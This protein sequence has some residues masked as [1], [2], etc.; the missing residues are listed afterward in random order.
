[1]EEDTNADCSYSKNLV[2]KTY[3]GHCIINLKN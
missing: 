2:N 3:F 1:M